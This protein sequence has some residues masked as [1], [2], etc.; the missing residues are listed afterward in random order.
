LH[1]GS[2][3]IRADQK[4]VV[5]P[6]SAREAPAAGPIGVV[7][8]AARRAPDDRWPLL[9]LLS[10]P[11]VITL[12]GLPYYL[13]P[14]AGRLRSPLH[15]WLKPS[16]AVGLTLGIVGLALFLFMWLYPLRKKYRWLAFTGGIASWM[17][18][19]TLAGLVL[20]LLVAVHA[21]WRFEGLIGLG[22]AA[23]LLVAL[24][25]VVGRYIYVRIPRS[26]T[27]LELGMD[28]TVNERL[29]LIT[30][31]AAATGLDPR[32]VE[33]SLAT[34]PRSYEGLGPLRTILR[35]AS[36]DLE[37][38]RAV[39]GLEARWS[40]A[41]GA[42]PRIERAALR[43]ALRLAR[44]EM[45]LSQQVRMLEATRR[46]FAL[47]H[48]AHRPVAITALLAVLIHVVVAVVVGGIGLR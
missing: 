40:R 43:E 19:H 42:G 6:S 9:A 44:R 7:P 32:E 23:L 37:R 36:D 27:G 13:L 46:V 15:D 21:G 24:S 1:S 41:R 4:Q 31:I 47:W 34:H 14:R 29:A 8:R 10:I 11:L 48:V 16:G 35:M 25:G 22:Y 45:A 26:R 38:W 39:R 30:R 17:R 3:A 18:V 2:P 20:P 33:R 5:S 28:E 12:L